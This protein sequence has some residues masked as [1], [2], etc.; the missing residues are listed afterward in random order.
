[1]RAL[2]NVGIVCASLAIAGCGNKWDQKAIDANVKDQW[3]HCQIVVP[4]KIVI[5][6][7]DGKTV[8]YSY[9]LRMLQ[10]GIHVRNFPC[11][12]P[13]ILMLEALANKDLVQLKKGMEV[14][15]TQEISAR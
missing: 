14:P 13:D 4:E 2:F 8:R 5:E 10:D 15:V 3:R 6:S 7:S 12:K 9:V 1:M 11:Y